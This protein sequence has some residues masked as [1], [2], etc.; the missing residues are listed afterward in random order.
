M[1]RLGWGLAALSI[2]V[3]S[4]L[5]VLPARWLLLAL[6]EDSPVSIVDASGTLW[7]GEARLALGFPGQRST[8]ANALQWRWSW[9]AGPR[10]VLEH[11]WLNQAMPVRFGWRRVSLPARDLQ[12]PAIVLTQLG[13]PFNTL[14][15][16]G[17]LQLSWPALTLGGAVQQ[18]L[19]A[20]VHWRQAGTA[21]SLLRPLGDYRA[22][23]NGQANALHL[24]VSTLQGVL[25]VEGKGNWR[26]SRFDYQGQARPAPASTPEQRIALDA[27]LSAIGTRSGETSVMKFQR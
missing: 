20:T 23:L 11:P 25:L 13:A 10:L 16:S 18:G 3:I 15:P 21:L 22:T 27:V 2:I 5:A 19:L 24:E 4:A 8:L 7:H 12:L 9:Q 1:K 14:Q 26:G 17:Q 6:P